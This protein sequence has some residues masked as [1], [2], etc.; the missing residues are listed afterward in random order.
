MQGGDKTGGFCGEVS[1]IA[2]TEVWEC[3]LSRGL[4]HFRP[5]PL[6][7]SASEVGIQVSQKFIPDND[8]QRTVIAQYPLVRNGMLEFADALAVLEFF[9]NI[10]PKRT[11]APERRLS[12][13]Q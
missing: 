5:I 8:V 12:C 13:K 1:G 9:N 3:P 11:F 4:G 7:N 6:K 2:G 10:S